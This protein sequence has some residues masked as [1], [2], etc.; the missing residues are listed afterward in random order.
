MQ[1]AALAMQEQEKLANE[2]EEKRLKAALTAKR[3]AVAVIARVPSPAVGPAPAKDS[4]VDTP[5]PAVEVAA[6]DVKMEVDTSPAVSFV[7]QLRR[8]Q[9]THHRHTSLRV[10]GYQN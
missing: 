2:E 7:P 6:K 4:P 3:E 1:K 9:T 5:I 8:N 10:L